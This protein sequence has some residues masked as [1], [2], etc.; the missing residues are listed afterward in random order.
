MWWD[1]L[2]IAFLLSDERDQLDELNQFISNFINAATIPPLHRFRNG[3]EF[4]M[5]V[6]IGVKQ[7]V[8]A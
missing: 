8:F 1:K 3:Y 4:T 7:F 2:V 5:A 6:S